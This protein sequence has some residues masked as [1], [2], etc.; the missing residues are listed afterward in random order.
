MRWSKALLTVIVFAV[1]SVLLAA[2]LQAPPVPEEPE[3]PARGPGIVNDLTVPGSLTARMATIRDSLTVNG[4]ASVGNLSANSLVLRNGELEADAITVDYLIAEVAGISD[5]L[6]VSNVIVLGDMGVQGT[7]FPQNNYYPL[8]LSGNI[9]ES[10]TFTDTIAAAI[11]PSDAVV[12]GMEFFSRAISNTVECNVLYTTTG[13]TPTMN[14][15]AITSTVLTA[16]EVVTSSVDN[17]T[18]EAGYLV[19]FVCNTDAGGYARDAM[20]TLWLK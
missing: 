18:L 3:E 14:T 12:G 1:L 8:V 13:I 15:I 2:C 7:I 11:L 20:V 6:I 10:F 9:T 19:E 16:G 4:S 5:T 17:D